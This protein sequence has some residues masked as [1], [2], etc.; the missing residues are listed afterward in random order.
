[1][2]KTATNT[3]ILNVTKQARLNKEHVI[4][5]HIISHPDTTKFLASL[6]ALPN[7]KEEIIYNLGRHLLGN[8]TNVHAQKFLNEYSYPLITFDSVPEEFDLLGAAYQYLNTKYENLTMGSFYTS[9][10][11]AYDIVKS[12]TFTNGETL[13]DPSCG[14][15]V[16]LFASDAPAEQIYGVD[17]DPIAVMIAKF[18]FFLKFPDAKIYPQIYEADFLD[19]YA[20]NSDKKFTYITGNPPYG[21]NLDLAAVHSKYITTGE[22]FSYFIEYSYYLL[23]DNGL[24]SY[25]LPEAILNVKRHVDIRDFILEEANLTRIKLYDNKFAGVM[26]DIYLLELDKNKTANVSFEHKGKTHS[27]PKT[28]FKELK[29][30][31]FAP[32][33]KEDAVIIKK[34]K[35]KSPHTLVGS[36]FAL[37][38]VTGDNRTK[39]LDKPTAST[40]TIITGKEVEKYKFLPV[41]K[42]I[43]FDRAK[44]QQVAPDSVYRAPEKLVYKVISK[45]FKVAIDLTQ[46]LTVSSANIVIPKVKGNTVY[47]IALLLNSDLYSYLNQKLHG[48]SNKVSRGNLEAL[49][50]PEFTDTELQSIEKMVKSHIAGTLGEDRLQQYVYTFFDIS[51]AEQAY[52]QENLE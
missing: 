33:P 20:A 52:I 21:A 48:A 39:L 11:L 27:I 34:V 10:E 28:V 3:T 4:P 23:E 12:F 26:S 49:P 13:V 1:M 9:R 19:W 37:G 16:F 15:G 8:T 42:H 24:L 18:N 32:S 17:F 22:S 47:S 44:L 29:N 51:E 41:K 45:R 14:S 50:I 43:V 5:K 38:V 6:I 46:G 7:P 2:N 40:E 25:L 35:N 36:T 30:H 31:V